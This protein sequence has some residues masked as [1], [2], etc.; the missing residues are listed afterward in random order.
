MS[1]FSAFAPM[2]RSPTTWKPPCWSG[3]SRS[4]T[5]AL[6]CYSVP[7]REENGTGWEKHPPEVRLVNRKRMNWT[8]EMPPEQS[9][10]AVLNGDLLSFREP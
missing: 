3:K 5:R 10:G 9:C 7:I 2:R 4:P 8:G 1:G 6:A